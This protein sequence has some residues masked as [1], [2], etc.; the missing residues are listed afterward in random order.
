M[1]MPDDRL[2]T[3]SCR[4]RHRLNADG[5]ALDLRQ[6]VDRRRNSRP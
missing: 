6:A 5:V 4:T 1:P 3:A 2:L